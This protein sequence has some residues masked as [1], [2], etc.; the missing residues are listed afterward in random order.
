MLI[1]SGGE[2]EEGRSGAKPFFLMD[3]VRSELKQ[4]SFIIQRHTITAGGMMSIKGTI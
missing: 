1:E 3:Y 4:N 2:R